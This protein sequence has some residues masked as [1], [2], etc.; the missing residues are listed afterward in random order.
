MKFKRIV[1]KRIGFSLNNIF[2]HMKV[3]FKIGSERVEVKF[4][5]VPYK[6]G[7]ISL[8]AKSS[9]DLDKLESLIPSGVSGDVIPKILQGQIEKKLGIIVKWDARYQ[10][11]GFGFKIDMYKI[12]DKLGK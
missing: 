8:I 5:P 3:Q 4:L 9:K 10:G 6:D 7:G 2:I 12:V 1:K 11:A